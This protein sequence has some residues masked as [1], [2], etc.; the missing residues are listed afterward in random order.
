MT[1]EMIRCRS[2]SVALRLAPW[3][4]VLAKVEGG[5]MAFESYADYRTWRRQR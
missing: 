3:A 4:C 5:F 2:R 1:T